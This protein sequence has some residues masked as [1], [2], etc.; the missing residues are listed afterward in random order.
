MTFGWKSTMW[1][2]GLRINPQLD[3]TWNL[4]HYRGILKERIEISVKQDFLMNFSLTTF[5]EH[6]YRGDDSAL[7]FQRVRNILSRQHC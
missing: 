1:I 5:K 6:S 7:L 3:A 2:L 4:S